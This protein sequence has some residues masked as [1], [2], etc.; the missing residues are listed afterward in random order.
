MR[1]TVLAAPGA[2][3]ASVAC[4][5]RNRD[6]PTPVPQRAR[7]VGAFIDR[8]LHRCGR[9]RKAIGV[10]YEALIFDCKLLREGLPWE[11]PASTIAAEIPVYRLPITVA[12]HPDVRQL[13][14]SHHSYSSHSL[15][16]AFYFECS[17]DSSTGGA[18]LAEL[19]RGASDARTEQPL[20]E[21]GR[22]SFSFRAPQGA[23]TSVDGLARWQCRRHPPHAITRFFS[24]SV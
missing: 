3:R 5:C 23:W 19:T 24:L 17:G 8:R 2:R 14:R 18:K 10:A 16:A 20:G 15:I 9:C 6:S 22:S 21:A 7:G 13:H 4:S 12:R 11:F 1:T